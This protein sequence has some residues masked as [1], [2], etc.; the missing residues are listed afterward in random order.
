GTKAEDRKA[1]PGC[2]TLAAKIAPKV[3]AAITASQAEEAVK[4]N[5]RYLYDKAMG[6]G[7]DP[8]DKLIG[9]Q[10]IA[11]LHLA[12]LMLPF[13]EWQQAFGLVDD[14]GSLVGKDACFLRSGEEAKCGKITAA[15]S[16]G[17]TIDGEKVGWD[18]MVSGGDTALAIGDIDLIQPNWGGGGGGTNNDGFHLRAGADFRTI[19][20]EGSVTN[21]HVMSMG[22]GVG[23]TLP[24]FPITGEVIFGGRT[25]LNGGIAPHYTEHE[26]MSERWTGYAG[27]GVGYRPKFTGWLG[28]HSMVLGYAHTNGGGGFDTELG[29]EFYPT[30]WLSIVTAAQGGY[31]V[32]DNEPYGDNPGSTLANPT[33]EGGHFGGTLQLVVGF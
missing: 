20:M 17:V 2:D 21:V 29:L 30:S 4:Q 15:D 8:N 24:T 26:T 16:S 5:A 11:M 22:V 18:R 1:T 23:Y 13:G 28:M 33:P 32:M 3:D 25:S 7:A 27:V 31:L 9:D 12:G 10:K 19:F 14:T 6:T